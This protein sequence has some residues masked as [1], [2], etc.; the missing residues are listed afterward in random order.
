MSVMSEAKVNSIAFRKIQPKVKYQ[1]NVRN[2]GEMSA[3]LPG[4]R[5]FHF[6]TNPPVQ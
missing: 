6:E 4:I 1:R 3:A 5:G 2:I